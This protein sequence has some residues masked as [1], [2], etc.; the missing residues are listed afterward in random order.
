MSRDGGATWT[1]EN[2]IIGMR[3]MDF[4]SDTTGFGGRLV[5]SQTVGGVFK[6][7]GNMTTATEELDAQIISKLNVY[8][9]P[10]QNEFTIENIDQFEVKNASIYSLEGKLLQSI[11]KNDIQDKINVS[12]L[13]K[14]VYVIM[15]QTKSGNKFAQKFMKK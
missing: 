1:L 9:N 8:P 11:S 5:V 6:W 3:C 10:V 12:S 13:P 15:L 2:Q 7:I 4:I 14:G